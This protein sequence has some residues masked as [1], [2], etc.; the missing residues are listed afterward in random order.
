M[1]SSA[2]FPSPNT[3]LSKTLSKTLLSNALLASTVLSN[4]L[5]CWYAAG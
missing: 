3:L 1:H 5:L 2:T 4:T